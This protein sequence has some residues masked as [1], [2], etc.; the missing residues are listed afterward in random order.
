MAVFQVH[1]LGLKPSIRK[2]Q[3][4]LANVTLTLGVLLT[5]LGLPHRISLSIS[6][7]GWVQVFVPDWD[8]ECGV[9]CIAVWDCSVDW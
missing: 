1:H 5:R 4:K 2:F 7:I 3:P 6:I 9:A 8:I